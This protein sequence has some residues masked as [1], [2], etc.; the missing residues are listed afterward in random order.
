MKKLFDDHYVVFMMAAYVIVAKLTDLDPIT[1]GAGV[2][3]FSVTMIY[4][5]LHDILVALRE[6]PQFSGCVINTQSM[7]YSPKNAVTLNHQ[8]PPEKDKA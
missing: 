2:V 8:Q 5:K 7:T 6:Q 3:G 4:M 1:T